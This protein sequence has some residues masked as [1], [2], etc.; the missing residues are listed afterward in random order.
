MQGKQVMKYFLE[1]IILL[2]LL[3][4]SGELFSEANKKINVYPLLAGQG[5]SKE[6][7]SNESKKVLIAIQELGIPVLAN[8]PEEA[9]QTSIPSFKKLTEDTKNKGGDFFLWGKYSS[10]RRKL[11]SQLLFSRCK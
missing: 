6:I 4:S 10:F 8:Q 5:I 7:A 3:I 9:N 2:I 1:K 11:L